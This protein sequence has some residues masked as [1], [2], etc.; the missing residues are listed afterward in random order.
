MS[1]VTNAATTSELTFTVPPGSA[2]TAPPEST[3][4]ERDD[5]RLLVARHRD[6]PQVEHR[7]FRDLP[8][9]LARGDVL[10]VNTSATVG[11][12]VTGTDVRGDHS[13]NILVHVSA[14][15]DDGQWVVEIRTAAND[16]PDLT[17]ARGDRITLPGDVV[18]TLR[19]PYPAGTDTPRLWTAEVT[20]RTSR[21]DYLWAFGRPITY[22]Y[23]TRRFPLSAYQTVFATDPGSAEMPSAGRPFT[24]RGVVDLVTRGITL[25]PVT[26]HC[27]VSSPDAG[28]MPSPERF[29]VP[30]DTARVVNSAR[31]AGRRIVAVGTSAVRAL[32]TATDPDGNVRE[33]SGWTD[34][35]LG[36]DRP[37]RTVNGLVTGLHMPEASHLRLLEAVAGH[38]L[39]AAAYDA[40]V[41]ARYRWHEFGDSNLFLP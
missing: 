30:S 24:E 11:A 38:A 33:S 9:A 6:A 28:E 34:L 41:A 18:L 16:G 31:D 21:T 27:G 12:A 32:E 8:S 40:S 35:V 5:V 39:V 1:A 25:A 13:G 17:R 20:P 14:E 19:A 2:A 29:A 37:A 26:L 23:V 3:G 4:H 7:T 10:V 22:E 36:P 15:L